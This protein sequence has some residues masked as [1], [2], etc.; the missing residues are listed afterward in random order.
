L[1]IVPEIKQA[2]SLH[3]LGEQGL[4]LIAVARVTVIMVKP[5]EINMH[6]F[7]KV[8]A[9]SAIVAACFTAGYLIG[10]ALL[11]LL[12]LIF[13]AKIAAWIYTVI[14]LLSCVWIFLTI[15][16]RDAYGYRK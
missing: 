7:G 2:K 3:L 9:W 1:H 13:G 10:T 14:W 4:T 15:F 8:C 12:T 11:W 16:E 5:Q 6:K